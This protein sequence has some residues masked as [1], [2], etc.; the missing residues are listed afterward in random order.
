M[1]AGGP[2]QAGCPAVNVSHCYVSKVG[3]RG[4]CRPR[5]LTTAHISRWAR[6]GRLAGRERQPLLR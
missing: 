3:L 2:A 1:I 6:V 4:P 5:E